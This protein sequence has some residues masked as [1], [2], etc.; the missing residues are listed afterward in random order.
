MKNRK[1]LFKKIIEQFPNSHYMDNEF[2]DKRDIF[3]YSNILARRMQRWA[4]SPNDPWQRP[5][6]RGSCCSSEQCTCR[7]RVCRDERVAERRAAGA[8]WQLRRQQQRRGGA[9][10]ERVTVMQYHPEM[11]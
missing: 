4:H 10:A 11:R 1:M 5:Q 7:A 3:Y 6:Q 2:T 9:S 8:N